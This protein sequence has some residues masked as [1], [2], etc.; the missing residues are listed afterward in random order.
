[1]SLRFFPTTDP[2]G[3]LGHVLLLCCYHLWSGEG[4]SHSWLGWL[5]EE[6]IS[7]PLPGCLPDP[8]VADEKW[9]SALEGTHWLDHVR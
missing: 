1:M 8:A 6:S 9:L 5:L 2:L 3:G 4:H 7:V